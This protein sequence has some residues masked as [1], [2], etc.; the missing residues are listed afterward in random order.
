MTF[1]PIE[2]RPRKRRGARRAVLWLAGLALA[3]ILFGV[4]VAVGEAL[5]DNPEPGRT[6]TSVRT[7]HP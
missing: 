6:V 1:S 3:A 4:G 5:H 2:R 7:L